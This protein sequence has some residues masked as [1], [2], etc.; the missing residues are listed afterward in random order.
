MNVL[1]HSR[2]KQSKRFVSLF[3][4]FSFSFVF[5]VTVVLNVVGAVVVILFVLYSCFYASNLVPLCYANIC[6]FNLI[7]GKTSENESKQTPVEFVFRAQQHE[8]ARHL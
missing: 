4:Y 6:C 2:D 3:G 7:I 5:S 8:G 1:I